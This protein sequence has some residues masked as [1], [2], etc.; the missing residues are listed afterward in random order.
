MR[1]C[2]HLL[3]LFAVGGTPDVDVD[4]DGDTDTA[5]LLALLAALGGVFVS[6]S[7]LSSTVPPSPMLGSEENRRRAPASN[8]TATESGLSDEEHSREADMPIRV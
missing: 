4:G 1:S 2:D 7:C 6:D 8:R 3:I 5:D